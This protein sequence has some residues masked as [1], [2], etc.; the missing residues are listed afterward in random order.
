MKSANCQPCVLLVAAIVSAGA[1]AWACTTFLLDRAGQVA[2]GK[3]YDWDLAQGMLV[4]NKRGVAKQA[5]PPAPIVPGTPQQPARWVSKYA[6]LTFNQYGREM[7]TGGMNE[8]GLVVEVMWLDSTVY[9]AP[10]GRPVL[11]GLQ[12]IQHALDSYGSV[13]EAVAHAQDLRVEDHYGKVHYLACDKGGACAAFEHLGGKMVVTSG[14]RLPIRTLTNHS[15]AE[16]LG[17]LRQC[18]GFGGSRAI[19]PGMGSLERFARA[20]SQT[21]RPPPGDLTTRAFGIL[22]S[23]R[24]GDFTKWNI[25]YEPQRLRV[26]FRVTA[27][28]GPAAGVIKYVD[29]GAF[30]RACGTPVQVLGLDDP[31]PGDA[32]AR[33]GLYDAAANRRL[34]AAGMHGLE[35]KMPPPALEQLITDLAEYPSRLPCAT[36]AHP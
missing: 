9:P 15:Y 27:G 23:V 28:T 2:I 18:Q 25:V 36:A 17:F 29:F 4:T 12:W 10:D 33:F 20:A 1:P 34:V 19:G 26:S 24:N 14:D 30:P 21:R 31:R 11:G 13:A 8:A 22:D 7:P 16:S 6:S 35:H 5:F 3:S 32:S